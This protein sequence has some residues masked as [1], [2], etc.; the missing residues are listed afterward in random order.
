[1][2]EKV[3]VGLGAVLLLIVAIQSVFLY[4]MSGQLGRIS[5]HT[6]SNI[7]LTDK[8][9]GSQI[10]P[11][12]AQV[13]P[14]KGKSWNPFEEMQRMQ[15]EMNKIFGDM[16]SNLYLR[17]DFDSML[18]PFSFSPTLDIREDADQ[19]VIKVDIPGSDESNIN[20]RIDDQRLTISATTKKSN[21]SKDHGSMFRSERFKGQFERS[22]DLPAPVLAEKMKTEY[23]DG[24]LIII[25]PKA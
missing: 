4:R 18:K 2:K 25:V 15:N 11:P 10:V 6:E 3:L 14:D 24:V 23:K 20:V 7:S 13:F 16:R 9:S 12:G 22:V 8:P 5:Q 21:E 19:F 1:M 17:P